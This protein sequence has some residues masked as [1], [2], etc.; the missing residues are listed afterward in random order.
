MII[1]TTDK[2][3]HNGN[4]I[5]LIKRTEDGS[6]CPYEKIIGQ[7]EITFVSYDDL[8]EICRLTAW[9][10]QGFLSKLDIAVV[11]EKINDNIAVSKHLVATRNTEKSAWSV[12]TVF[13]AWKKNAD[14]WSKT[15]ALPTENLTTINRIMSHDFK[16]DMSSLGINP[17][18]IQH[19]INKLAE[20]IKQ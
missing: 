14:V 4:E 12:K 8:R 19:A 20:T 6:F 2:R 17:A 7:N 16:E 5:V 1:R 15:S 18:D 13:V 3:S 10:G 11:S 9:S